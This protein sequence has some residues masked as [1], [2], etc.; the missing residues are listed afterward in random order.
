[1][2][3][4]QKVVPE[5]IFELV[6]EIVRLSPGGP[7]AGGPSSGGPIPPPPHAAA[8]GA[9]IDEGSGSGSGVGSG[10]EWERVSEGN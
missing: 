5:P 2:A 3:V 6:L 9:D 10:T 7:G 1:M 4:Y 8:R